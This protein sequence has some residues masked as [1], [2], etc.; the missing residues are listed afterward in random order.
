MN[1][2]WTLKYWNLDVIDELLTPRMKSSW[3]FIRALETEY[4]NTES[5]WVKYSHGPEELVVIGMYNIVA[6]RMLADWKHYTFEELH[7]DRLKSVC[8]GGG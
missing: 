7:S 3:E 1:Y 5:N 8:R 4:G 2:D 6:I